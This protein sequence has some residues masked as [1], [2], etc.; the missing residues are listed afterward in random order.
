VAGA[1]SGGLPRI[2]DAAE[3]RQNSRHSDRVEEQHFSEKALG[4]GRLERWVRPSVG[5]ER[6]RKLGII[7]RNHKLLNPTN[8]LI[9]E[10]AQLGG[11]AV[12]SD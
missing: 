9:D 2:E 8:L 11:A 3:L 4:L 7:R 1:A 12:L 10:A 5:K 6:L